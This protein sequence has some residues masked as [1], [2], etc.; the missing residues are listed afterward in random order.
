ML[1]YV[2]GRRGAPS[3]QRARAQ[4]S[5][6]RKRAQR[7]RKRKR[8]SPLEEPP[9][10]GG[11]GAAGLIAPRR[12]AAA[13]ARPPWLRLVPVI[14]LRVRVWGWMRWGRR[15]VGAEGSC[16]RWQLAP[17]CHGVESRFSGDT[18]GSPLRCGG[19]ARA[20]RQVTRWGLARGRVVGHLRRCCGGRGPRRRAGIPLGVSLPRS[21]PSSGLGLDVW[22]S[23]VPVLGFYVL[24][25]VVWHRDRSAMPSSRYQIPEIYTMLVKTSKPRH[26]R[27]LPDEGEHRLVMLGLR[28]CPRQCSLL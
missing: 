26:S 12:A 11:S 24:I 19:A 25:G 7:S 2:L 5:R 14:G 1:T 27:G 18:S 28:E 10:F 6:K 15:S 8:K 20:P 16:K 21:L 23:L 9:R 22:H 4:R 13:P 17:G 3:P